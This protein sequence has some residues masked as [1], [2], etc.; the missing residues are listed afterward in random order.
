[1]EESLSE[2]RIVAGEDNEPEGLFG[3][4]DLQVSQDTEGSDDHEETI[5]PVEDHEMSGSCD[6]DEEVDPFKVD[7]GFDLGSVDFNNLTLA[8]INMF[9]FSSCDVAFKFYNKY[10]FKW[11]FAARKWNVV[12]NK[13]GEVTQQTFVCFKEGFRLKKHLQRQNR[14]REP[15]PMTR[16]GCSTFFR[17]RYVGGTSPWHVKEFCDDHTHELLDEKYVGMLL[18]HRKMHDCDVMQMNS[19]M[20]AGIG[21]TQIY[22][23][24]ANQSGGYERLGFRK[25]DMYNEIEK[26]R[27]ILVSDGN[28]W[29]KDVYEKRKMWATTHIRGN[30]FA[31]FRTTSRYKG[32]HAQVGRYVHY[33]NNL[34]EFLKHFSRYLAY[35]RQRELEDDFDS[36]I[37][38]PVLQTTVEDIERSTSKVYTRKRSCPLRQWYVSMEPS[39]RRS[40][41]DL[42]LSK[43]VVRDLLH[44]LRDSAVAPDQEGCN[45]NPIHEDEWTA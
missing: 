26:Q 14:K 33:R 19:M 8:D 9:H 17:V 16:C 11:G 25:R 24:A 44:R 29:V 42:H 15:R 35:T 12:K 20:D 22:G 2:S 43:K 30:F 1:M 18:A 41:N 36:I 3:W 28:Q 34:T 7:E 45:V 37:G 23:L 10:A 31:G 21:V 5:G 38:E 39:T 40:A 27:R 6:R 13:K 4:I 32:M